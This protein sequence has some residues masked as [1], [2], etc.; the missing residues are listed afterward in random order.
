L[1]ELVFPQ[2]RIRFAEF[3]ADPHTEELFKAGVRLKLPHQ[4]FCVLAMLLER[5]GQL[6][7]RDELRT[8]LWPAST[9]VEYDQRL[10]A[11]V[12]RLREAL[13][14]SAEAPRFIET[15]PKR[16][17][18]F[19]ATIE[20]VSRSSPEVTHSPPSRGAAASEP[21]PA[22]SVH[23]LS[24]PGT[25]PRQRKIL[26]AALAGL[27]AILLFTIAHFRMSAPAGS[28]AA[29]G[30]QLLPLAS[31]P[32]RAMAPT[33]SP[34]GSQVA[35]AWN[36]GA[37]SGHLFDLYVKSLGSERLLRLTHQPSKW[38][39]AAWAPDGSTIAF[40]RITDE[41]AGIF[42][43]PALGG[44]ERS[45]VS[46]GVAIGSV[47]ISWSAD[48][49]QLAY[50]GYGPDAA[51]IEIVSLDTGDTR[52]LSPAPECMTAVNPAFAPDG[53]QLALVCVSS[54]GVYTIYVVPLSDGR[55][56]AGAP[57]ALATM[58]GEPQG[59]A[60]MADGSGLI[61]SNDPGDGGELWQLTLRGEREQLPFGENG[62]APTVAARGGRIAYVRSRAIVDI[63]RADLT[64]A[65]PEESATKL[66][67]STRMQVL[68]R[69]SRDGTR[70][71]FQSNRSGSFE[72]WMTDAQ[73]ADPDR[74]TSFNGPLT[75]APSWCSD[76]RRIAFD[77][78]L[79]GSSA[80][81]IEDI[82]ERV[83][84]KLVTS[85]ENLSRPVWSEDCRWLFA[86]DGNNVLYRIAATG[87]PAERFT[88]H[89]SSYCV[90]SADRVIFNVMESTGVLLWMRSVGGGA[91]AP[92]EGMPRI[93]YE[94]AWAATPAGIYFTDSS[95][96]PVQVDYYDLSSRRTRTL[97]TLKQTPVPG[98]GPGISVSPDGHW[99]LY[100]Q[101]GDESSEIMLAPA[102]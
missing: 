22:D 99:L 95:S 17:Y 86:F 59:L 37:D 3:E 56:P 13:L 20:P 97:M 31:L 85:R 10:N 39:S 47:Q 90:V 63:W 15:L 45:I 41:S 14:D 93:R 58:M 5:P 60:W 66:I 65:H 49:H 25:M 50:S 19:I 7:T 24:P 79:S 78:R 11:A 51:Q 48:G 8:R 81:Y 74:L 94:D 71:A 28:G 2:Q 32:G 21:K 87:G 12:N 83:P 53:K 40:L 84:R 76:G 34:D 89:V 35:F 70:I 4:S 91:Q 82:N 1:I 46:S 102:R 18:R 61:V 38:M 42:V 29:F 26:L 88:E 67:Y 36:E 55:A 92:L 64:A 100:G 77:S 54:S 62:S 44:S 6:V 96:Q 43:I 73:G 30:R 69:Y 23:E 33:F 98:V 72:I 75:A 80:I 9:L 27:T 57:R 68:P 52:P 101:S 16:G